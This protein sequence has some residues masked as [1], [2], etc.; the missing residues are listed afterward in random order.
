MLKFRGQTDNGH[1]LSIDQKAFTK[2]DLINEFPKWEDLHY[3][4]ISDCEAADAFVRENLDQ[5]LMAPNG[6]HKL[7]GTLRDLYGQ[8]NI[9]R[10]CK[11]IIDSDPSAGLVTFLSVREF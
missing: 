10:Q 8:E 3:I 11:Q 5:P 6:Y 4:H 7:G 9:D 1:Q 2:E